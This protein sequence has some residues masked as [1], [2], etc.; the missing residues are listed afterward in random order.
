MTLQQI[1][2]LTWV[3]ILA[4]GV[5]LGFGLNMLITRNPQIVRSKKD[6]SLF[7]DPEGYAVHGGILMLFLALGAL[8]MTGL[9]FVN[10]VAAFIEA[11]VVVVAYAILWKRMHNKYGPF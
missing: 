1:L 9:L 5:S 11:V 10:V 3:P 4:F 2:D 7:K 8:I 6:N